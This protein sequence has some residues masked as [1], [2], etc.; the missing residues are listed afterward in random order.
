M[1]VTQKEIAEAMDI[2]GGHLS[3]ILSGVYEPGKDTAK[4]FGAYTG[5]PWTTFFEMSPDQ[6]RV[7]LFDAA[8]KRLA[9]AQ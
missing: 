2:S 5:I 7:A 4:R 8:K 9:S 6:I 1:K 3:L